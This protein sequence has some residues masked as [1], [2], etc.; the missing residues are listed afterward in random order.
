MFG[1][2][3]RHFWTLVWLSS[4]AEFK[5]MYVGSTLGSVLGYAWALVRPLLTFAVIY[6]VFNEILRVGDTVPHYAAMLIF[7]LTLF[8]FLAD[9]SGRAVSA[10]VTRE[11]VLR[12]AELPRA[13]IPVSIVLTGAFTFAL[14][15]IAV[16]AVVLGVGTPPLWTWLLLPVLW[17]VMLVFVT[18]ISVMLST[19]FVRFRDVAQIWTV[20][21]LMLFYF[22]PIMY[23][24][25]LIPAEFDW[26]LAVNP[27]A[28]IF[29][30][31]RIWTVDPG[32]PGPLEVTGNVWGL[33][34]PALIFGAVCVYAAHLLR[35]RSRTMAE[36]L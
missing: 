25:E 2:S 10:F 4:V 6:I 29:E 33:L 11:D 14:N 36:D 9:A 35:E 16:F 12:K 1:P 3:L 32:G 13:V 27:I 20:V 19:L 15:Q 7:N 24:V 26:L 34:G 18:A 8:F 23:P 5:L 31:M 30:Q 17:L 22:S 28:P 21:S